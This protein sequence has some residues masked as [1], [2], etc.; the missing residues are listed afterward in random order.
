MKIYYKGYTIECMSNQAWDGS[1]KGK[2]LV[3]YQ[4]GTRNFLISDWW[5]G[6]IRAGVKHGKTIVDKYL[7]LTSLQPSAS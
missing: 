4:N 6:N 2:T 5:S 1:F 3:V 7:D